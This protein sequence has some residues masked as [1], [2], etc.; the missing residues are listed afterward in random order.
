MIPKV[1]FFFLMLLAPHLLVAQYPEDIYAKVWEALGGEQLEGK[2]TFFGE[3]IW[4]VADDKAMK[5]I[6]RSKFPDMSRMDFEIDKQ[7]HTISQ[8]GGKAWESDSISFVFKTGEM[9]PAERMAFNESFLYENNLINYTERGLELGF[10]GVV[11]IGVEEFLMLR[12]KGFGHKEELYYIS[13]KTFLPVEKQSY[14]EVDGTQSSVS[15]HLENYQWLDG[16]LMP[17]AINIKSTNLTMEFVFESMVFNEPT[18]DD[19][20]KNSDKPDFLTNALSF[21]SLEAQRFMYEYIPVSEPMGFEV[22]ILSNRKVVMKAPIEINKNAYNGA[23]SASVDQLFLSAGIT[24]MR[25]VVHHLELQP[26][27]YGE[28]RNITF[29]RPITEDFSAQV[30]IPG[31]KELEQFL[32]DYER[33]GSAVITLNAIIKE[34]RNVYAVFEGDFEIVNSSF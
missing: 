34:G 18:D 16:V 6:Y 17:S 7:V 33:N 19:E 8:K 27:I 28:K 25:L 12:L 24:Y 4:S 15:F 3:G 22:E 31:K 9:N 13:Q 29:F 32:R 1:T 26:D 30:E 23:F 2:H 10:E 20:F 14:F 5:F 21:S 11:N